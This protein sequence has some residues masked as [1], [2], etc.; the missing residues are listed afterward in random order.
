MNLTQAT[1][2][3]FMTCQWKSSKALHFILNS[4]I[5]VQQTMVQRPLVTSENH[6]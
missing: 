5:I 6:L 1:Y 3:Y 2:F 4:Q